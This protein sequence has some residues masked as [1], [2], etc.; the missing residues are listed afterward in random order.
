MKAYLG[1]YEVEGFEFPKFADLIVAV[2]ILFAGAAIAGA[3]SA[4][5]F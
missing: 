3:L 5:I 2:A 1:H 4:L